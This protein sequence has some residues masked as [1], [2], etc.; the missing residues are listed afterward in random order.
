MAEK[1]ERRMNRQELEDARHIGSRIYGYKTAY[2]NLIP[3]CNDCDKFV[4]LGCKIMRKIEDL[5]IKRILW[6]CKG[7]ERKEDET[8]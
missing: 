6:I 5:Q 1:K 8:S 3:C 2:C 4:A 7:A